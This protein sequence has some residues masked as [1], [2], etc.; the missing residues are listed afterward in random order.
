LYRYT[1]QHDICLGSPIANRHYGETEG[2]IG[3][4]VNTLAL[5]N[6]VDGEQGFDA[7]LA[8]VKETC[9]QAYAHQDT[10]F[11]KVVDA[12]QPDR[13]TGISPLFQVMFVLQNT[14][15]E[16]AGAHIRSYPL[17]AESSKFDITLTFT[18]SADGLSGA[19]QYKTALYEAST[20]ARMAEH[21]SGFCEAIVRA[22]SQRVNEVEFIS[23]AEKQ[24]LLVEFN[25]TAASY[26]QDKCIHELF[27][28]QVAAHPDKIAVV[29]EGQQ[30]TYQA[31][32]EQS[33]ALA[34]Y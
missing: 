21:F 27:M 28:E 8:Q 33:H 7:L 9:L 12:V 25:Q 5:R 17:G 4:F 34:V 30:L 20:I 26:P 18:E 29:Y 14:P 19:L 1:G 32:Y 24:R 3:M 31:L 11:E 13:N 10:P 16:E 15:Q 2:L 23:A 6:Q 22:P